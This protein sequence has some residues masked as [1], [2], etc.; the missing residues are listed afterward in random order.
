M[1]HIFDETE[2]AVRVTASYEKFDGDFAKWKESFYMIWRYQLTW[3]FAYEITLKESRRGVFVDLLV[4]P[5]YKSNVADM[6]E[7]LGYKEVLY[8]DERVGVIYRY[9]NNMPDDIEYIIAE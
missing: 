4:K 5:A 8:D 6:M 3:N 1:K 2:K 7:D 9:D